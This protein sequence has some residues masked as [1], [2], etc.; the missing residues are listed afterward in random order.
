MKLPGIKRIF[1]LILTVLLLPALLAVPAR[2][3]ELNI[4]FINVLNYTTP[5]MSGENTVTVS[6][7]DKIVSFE[8]PFH[9][10]IRYLEFTFSF[11][12]EFFT[13]TVYL[14]STRTTNGI[15]GTVREQMQI[16]YM[17]N[18]VFKCYGT[19]Y[20]DDVT[21]FSL[22][23]ANFPDRRYLTFYDVSYAPEAV[24]PTNIVADG[25]INE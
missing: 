19:F 20:Y 16:V 9:A 21:F 10:D 24:Y 14:Q 8:L 23:F 3:D 17:G 6:P 15:V 2:A 25:A 12:G 22:E 13:P 1:P 11:S 4:D 7:Q 18:N 5:N